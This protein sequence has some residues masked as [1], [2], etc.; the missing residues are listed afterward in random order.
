[1][2]LRQMSEYKFLKAK[3][4]GK[5]NLVLFPKIILSKLIFGN[6]YTNIDSILDNF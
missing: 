6:F 5:L 1:M 4:F 3:S 2:N